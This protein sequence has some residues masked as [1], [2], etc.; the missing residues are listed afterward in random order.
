VKAEETR[1]SAWEY[2]GES[3]VEKDGFFDWCGSSQPQGN[4]D[5]IEDRR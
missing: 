4:E 2:R 5:S 1:A 3:R